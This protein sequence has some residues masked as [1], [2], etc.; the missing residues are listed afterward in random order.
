[1]ALRQSAYDNLISGISKNEEF[2]D[3][4]PM[5]ID[6]PYRILGASTFDTPEELEA[7]Y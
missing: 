5:I 6:N 2:K 1:M 7:L 3:A 4:F